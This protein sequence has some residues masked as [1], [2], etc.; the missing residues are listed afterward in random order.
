[1]L[2]L[3]L[4]PAPDIHLVPDK[5]DETG[6]KGEYY[7][8]VFPNE[9]WHLRQHYMELNSTTPSMP[10]QFTF[11][12]MSFFRFQ[13]FASMTHGFNEASKQNGGQASEVD[14][15][16]RML[17]ETNPWFLGLTGLVSILHVV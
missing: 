7:P 3:T 1:L 4:T 2:P 11:Q 12:P 15:I 10:V 8:V 9:F 17:L 16:K 5:R 6:T 13:I 14:E